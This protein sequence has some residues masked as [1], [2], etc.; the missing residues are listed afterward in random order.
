M[1][2]PEIL[3]GITCA[4]PVYSLPCQRIRFIECRHNDRHTRQCLAVSGRHV[5]QV[6]DPSPADPNFNADGSH[7]NK[8][9][10]RKPQ[11]QVGEDHV[12]VLCWRLARPGNLVFKS[13]GGSRQ[14][15]YT[16]TAPGLTDTQ[17]RGLSANRRCWYWFRVLSVW[18]LASIW[19]RTGKRQAGPGSV[20]GRSAHSGP[21]ICFSGSLLRSRFWACRC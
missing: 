19:L 4:A 11:R 1:C 12:E 3:Q 16:C 17:T 21:A 9:D 2:T 14:L 20:A 7:D 8:R 13:V 15:S 6:S 5:F 18:R 10:D